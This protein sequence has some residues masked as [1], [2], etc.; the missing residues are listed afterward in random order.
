MKSLRKLCWHSPSQAFTSFQ[1]SA[2][3]WQLSLL[4]LGAGVDARVKIIANCVTFINHLSILQIHI[5]TVKQWFLLK[6]ITLYVQ[7]EFVCE[8]KQICGIS[9]VYVRRS[10][11]YGCVHA[12]WAEQQIEQYNYM[13]TCKSLSHLYH[14]EYKWN[15]KYS[16]VNWIWFL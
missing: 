1:Q 7:I 2:A 8:M 6:Q 5:Q 15:W 9:A 4:L 10:V 11:P 14:I 13:P 3:V 16:T 12:S